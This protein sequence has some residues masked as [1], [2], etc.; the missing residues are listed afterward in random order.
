MGILKTILDRNL[1]EKDKKV[2]EEKKIDEL[3]YDDFM[4]GAI[5]WRIQEIHKLEIKIHGLGTEIINIQRYH[6]QKE[7]YK[8]YPNVVIEYFA[9]PDGL[10]YCKPRET[11]I[12]FNPDKIL[13]TNFSI[14]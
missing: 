14:K 8:T 13:K 9:R 2:L 12:G 11:T 1:A 7:R 4:D 3:K 10:A 6:Q 5:S